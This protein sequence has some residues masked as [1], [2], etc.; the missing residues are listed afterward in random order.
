M[1]KIVISLDN[2]N[3]NYKN[4][5]Q[6]IKYFS[7]KK[8][9]INIYV[10]GKQKDINNLT[11]IDNIHLLFSHKEGEEEN[12]IKLK[13]LNLALSTLEKEQGDILLSYLDKKE[14]YNLTL[15]QIKNTTTPFYLIR[16]LS[17]II[18][19][20]SFLA[21]CGL[22]DELSFDEYIS[23]YNTS[24]SFI[25]DV[26]FIKEPTFS[27]ASNNK[28]TSYLLPLENELYNE[29]KKKTNF[30]GI[31]NGYDIVRGKSDLYLIDAANASFLINGI[32]G[33]YESYKEKYD[34]YIKDDFTAKI[35]NF[36]AKKMNRFVNTNTSSYLERLGYY[37]LGKEKLI[38]K[39]FEEANP[40]DTL[41]MLLDSSK[42]LDYLVLKE[43]GN[44]SSKKKK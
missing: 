8:K 18:S 22:N 25:S 15:K 12:D 5:V 37:L 30:S 20:Y 35:S 40:Y 41:N 3:I 21:D 7:I 17:G 38:I 44:S 10:C 27:L 16:F 9:K 29:F 31:A 24:K 43:F 26:F 36:F 13:T 11:K 23:I 34:K 39:G 6:G 1:N 14:L 19:R 2:Q 32:K 28:E 42:Y 33:M 4:I